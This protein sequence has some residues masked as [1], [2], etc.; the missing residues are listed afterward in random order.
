MSSPSVIVIG[1]GPGGL[2]AARRLA[3]SGK[4]EVTL[5][6]RNGTATYLPGIVPTLLGLRAPSDYTRPVAIPAVNARAGEVA[7]VASG[8]VRLVSGEEITADAIIAAPGLVTDAAE[9]PA[10]PKSYPVWELDEAATAVAAVAEFFDGTLYI[11]I[12]GLPY[13]CPPAPYGLAISL[14]V[15]MRAL[16]RSVDVVLSTP[17]PRPLQGLGT[18]VSEFIERLCA[19]AKVELETGFVIDPQQSRDGLTI[20][21]DGRGIEVDLGLF[22][23]P[24]RRPA[25]LRGLPGDGPLVPVTPQMETGIP[26]LW[27]VGDAAGTALPRAAGVAEAQGHTAADSVLA[28]L[29]LGPAQPP[30]VPEPVCYLWAGQQAGR[31]RVRFPNGLPPAGTPEPALEEPSE[32]LALEALAAVEGWAAQFR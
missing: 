1:A 17:E 14:A 12:A 21:T 7:S 4:V 23:P 13:R 8:S 26:G 11:G 6:T 16:G 20:S 28:A 25:F 27:V 32:A 5:V 2:A 29:G 3:E 9:L 18:P 19:S 10:G 24:H 15:T 22:V 31:I 30:H